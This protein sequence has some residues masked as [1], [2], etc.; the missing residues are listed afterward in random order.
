MLRQFKPSHATSDSAL[1]RT[2][3]LE[4]RGADERLLVRLPAASL[5]NER[6]GAVL[7]QADPVAKQPDT[8]LLRQ[9]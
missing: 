5:R 3:D 8:I 2:R 9:R 4:L 6:E 7:I 1:R